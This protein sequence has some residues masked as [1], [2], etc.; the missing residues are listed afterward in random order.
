MSRLLKFQEIHL[1]RSGDN[2]NSE[3]GEWLKG[4]KVCGEC[5]EKSK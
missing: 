1:I 5:G 3:C 2:L 4:Q